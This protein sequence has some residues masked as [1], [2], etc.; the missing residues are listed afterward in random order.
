MQRLLIRRARV[1][2][3]A[4]KLD[5]VADLY[6]DQGRIEALGDLDTPADMTIDGRGWIV[7]PGLID[8]H[9]HLREPGKEEEETILSG[10]QAAVASGI[11]TLAC[12]PN[13]EPAVDN[14]A[15]AEFVVLQ[16]ERAGLANV[17]PIGAI[18]KRRE[19]RELAEIGQLV[20]GGAV[21]F[22]DD[23]ECVQNADVMRRALE[24]TRM[25]DKPVISHCEDKNLSGHGV[26]HAG[27]VSTILGLGGMPAA[28]EEIMVS[29]DT[30]LAKMTDGLLHIAHASSAGSVEMIRRAKA[31]G[32]RVTAEVTPHHL[33]LTDEC[34]RTFDSN[35]KMNP[36]LRTA[37]DIAALI[38][39][40]K[41]GTID[42]IA[43]DHAPHAPEEKDVEFSYAPFGVIGME[44][45]LAVLIKV[46]VET[47]KLTWLQLIEKLTVAP[48]RILRLKKGTLAVG[49]DADITVIDP[50]KKW[51]INP[52]EFR[53]KSRNCPFAGWEVTGKTVA[54]I[55]GGEIKYSE[56]P[57]ERLLS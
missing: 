33:S 13:T 6:V 28:A 48:A 45:E 32:V 53:S 20:R 47:G 44:S 52:N 57:P 14:E 43:S 18:T 5:K 12:M 16:G 46:L 22:S 1:L 31:A 17:L 15:S 30:I 4:Q 56:I 34:V 36:P 21:A 27:K 40:L 37:A 25:F 19:G 41:D 49:A 39:G 42:A 35:Y 11:T 38:E 26:M 24:Y 3:P 8:M 29:R 51:T 54:T 9:V 50:T 10:S 23:G 7:C 55:V 2:C